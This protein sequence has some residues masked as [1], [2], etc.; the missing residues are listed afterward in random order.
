MA[1][2]FSDSAGRIDLSRLDAALP[3]TPAKLHQ[4]AAGEAAKRNVARHGGIDDGAGA[5]AQALV[6]V[7]LSQVGN[8]GFGIEVALA[9]RG[10]DEALGIF[11]GLPAHRFLAVFHDHLVHAGIDRGGGAGK[12]HRAAGLGLQG[13][14]CRLQHMGER[15]IAAAA[16]GVQHAD[17]RKQGPQ[18]GFEAVHAGDGLFGLGAGHHGLDG[19]VAAPEVG[20]AQGPGARYIHESVFLWSIR[21]GRPRSVRGRWNQQRVGIRWAGC[22]R[23]AVR[24]RKS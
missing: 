24:A 11:K 1:N 9:Q 16:F 5:R 13:Q 21:A 4:A 20:A 10:V 17:G 23:T 22:S 6:F 8:G 3:G 12:G 18:P 7:Q 15:D 19:H 2:G 14:R